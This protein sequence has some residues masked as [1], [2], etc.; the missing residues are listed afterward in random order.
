MD[1]AVRRSDKAREQ[2]AEALSYKSYLI[3]VIFIH[4]NGTISPRNW[5]IN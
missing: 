3:Q 1:V 4:G 2:G 5:D